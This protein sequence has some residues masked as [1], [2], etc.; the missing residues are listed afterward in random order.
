MALTAG[1][2]EKV[3]KK[4]TEAGM[5]LDLTDQHWELI[6]FALGYYRRHGTMCNLRTL[7][8][9]SGYEKKAVYRLF[10]GNPIRRICALTGL[11]MP[12][13]C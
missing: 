10:P 13:E 5:D 7:I 11:P 1:Q 2:R 12:P 9:E 4:A 8:R 6:E 3:Q